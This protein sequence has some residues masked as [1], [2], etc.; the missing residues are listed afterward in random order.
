MPMLLQDVRDLKTML[1][2]CSNRLDWPIDEEWFEDVDDLVYD[3]SA[4]DLGIKDEEFAKIKSLKQVRPLEYDQ[5]WGIFAI[6]F[7]GDHIEVSALRRIIRKLIPSRNNIDF[8]TWDCNRILFLCFWGSPEFRTIGFVAFEDNGKTLPIIKTLYCT[9]RLEDRVHLENFES[10]ISVLTWPDINNGEDWIQNWSRFF[11]PAKGQVISDTLILTEVLA[12]TALSISKALNEAYDIETEEGFTHQLFNRFNGALRIQLS[13]QDFIDMYAQTIVYG[14]FSARCMHPEVSPFT[15]ETAIDCIPETNPLLRNLLREYFV[16]GGAMQFDELDIHELVDALNRTN[17]ELIL[18]DFNRQTGYSKEDPIIYFYEKF[19]DLYEHEERIRRGV[20]YTPI[21]AVN[22]IVHSIAYLLEKEFNCP[23]GFLC[24]AVSILD[25]ATGTGTFLRSIILETYGEYKKLH[26]TEGWNEYVTND[27]LSRLFG[28]ELM[29]APYAIAHMKLAL[30][31]KETGYEFQ[32]GRR[33]QVY[34]ANTLELINRPNDSRDNSDPLIDESNKANLVRSKRINVVLGNPPYRKDS[35]HNGEWIMGLMT[36]YK[37]E[38]GCNERLNER[39]PKVINN[40][41]VKF[42]RFA[43]ELVSNEENAIVGFVSANSF[44]DNI[45]FRGMRWSL[46]HSFDYIYI[47]D[48]HGNVMGRDNSDREEGDEPIFDNKL[49]ICIC[50]FVKTNSKTEKNAKVYYADMRGS[51]E[52]KYQFLSAAHIKKLSWATVETTEPY[53]FFKPKNLKHSVSYNTGIQLSA[54][55]PKY[56]GGIKTHHDE[57]LISKTPFNTG[58]DQLYDYRP[59]DIRHINYDRS[60]VERDR[61]DIMKHFLNHSNLGLVID[62]QVVNDNW[63]HIQVVKNMIDNRLHRSNRG[64]PVVCP[65]YLYDDNGNVTPNIDAGELS[66]LS[67]N[68]VDTPDILSVFDYCY[69]ILHSSV[70]RAK[71]LDLLSIDFPRVPIPVGED[72]FRL[73]V[74]VGAHLRKL[75]LFEIPISNRLDIAFNGNGDNVVGRIRYRNNCVYINRTQYFSNVREDIWDFCFA[76]YHGL[77]KWLKD[78]NGEALSQKDIQHLIN[79]FN[80]FDYTES[81]MAKVDEILESY[82]II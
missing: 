2:Y 72:M 60:K 82:E 27:L 35:I 34:L 19:L 46:L 39:N 22:F 76:G 37:H 32:Q 64:I 41:Y 77:Q 38:P 52:Q 75:H 50:F 51:R 11:A 10:R 16:P 79:V 74:E 29:M 58:F 44:T 23:T 25:P 18:N 61:Y 33:L 78:H 71:Y 54:L 70:Y 21:P 4:A 65:M 26:G 3:F 30:T 57:I 69:G 28:L 8:K 68:L 36:D 42:I 80:I 67:V 59:F 45:T 1:Q 66:R 17:I 13:E 20:Y 40:D 5:P 62:R 63:S 81:D 31:L 55:F 49:G 47:F 7:I 9:P 24:P 15:V 43:Q 12:N 14:L 48:L 56:L 6:D 73:V 53:Y